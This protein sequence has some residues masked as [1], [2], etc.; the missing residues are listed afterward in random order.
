MLV[1]LAI[2]VA[3]PKPH[4]V[5]A[6]IASTILRLIFSVGLQPT[7]FLLGAFNV[8]TSPS[9]L[10]ARDMQMALPSCPGPR[11]GPALSVQKN[12]V[13]FGSAGKVAEARQPLP[14]P[15]Q[16]RSVGGREPLGVFPD[17]ADT[18]FRACSSQVGRKRK[19]AEV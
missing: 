9:H 15:A 4:G 2:V 16:P 1:S 17:A 14:F 18:A 11:R 19:A 5:R 12:T 13:P 3:L 6:L 8:S 10:L 7:L